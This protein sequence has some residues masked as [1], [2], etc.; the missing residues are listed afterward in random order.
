MRAA[1][2]SGSEVTSLGHGVDSAPFSNSLKCRRHSG[3]EDVKH[4]LSQALLLER[5]HLHTRGPYL[6]S[7]A[8]ATAFKSDLSVPKYWKCVTQL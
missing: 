8:E 7:E 3:H 1:Q 2:E 4:P 5:P 6:R